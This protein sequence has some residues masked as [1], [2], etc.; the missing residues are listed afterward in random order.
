MKRTGAKARYG[1]ANATPLVTDNYEESTIDA[2]ANFANS[3][4]ADRATVS[5][6]TNTI[7]ELTTELKD[8]LKKIDDLQENL[9]VAYLTRRPG[10]ENRNTNAS[11]KEKREPNEPTHY[12]FTHGFMCDHPSGRCSNPKE[13]HQQ[14]AWKQDTMGGCT[15]NIEKFLRYLKRNSAK[16]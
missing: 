10:R 16:K 11:E 15:D 12:C 3:T 5:K 14:K 8:A 4:A 1:V 2:L 13:G 9:A 7:Q 6:L